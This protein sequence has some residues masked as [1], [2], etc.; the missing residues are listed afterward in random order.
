VYVAIVSRSFA[1][2]PR[3]LLE[4]G[5]AWATRRPIYVVRNDI[6][7]D[8]LPDFFQQFRS[9]PH[10]DDLPKLIKDIRKRSERVPV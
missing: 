3:L 7:R 6:S 8:E 4:G 10:W 5:A 9:F 2:D 1:D